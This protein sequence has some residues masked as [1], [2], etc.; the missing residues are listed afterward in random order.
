MAHGLFLG[1]DEIKS[2]P[3]F[4]I[5]T[6]QIINVATDGGANERNYDATTDLDGNG[7]VDAF[8]DVI[9]V[10]DN[11]KIEGLDEL[12]MEG[13]AITDTLRDWYKDWA[14]VP[15]PGI[16]APPFS[17]PGWI[18][19]VADASEFANTIGQKLE[20]IITEETI[21][22]VPSIEGALAAGFL[23]VGVISMVSSLASAVSNL[24]NYPSNNLAYKINN[25]L[26]G[27]FKKWLYEFIS[28]KQKFIV[29]QK[30]GSPFTLT[31]QE[32]F[33]FA[34]SLSVLT[35]VFSY[36]KAGNFNQIL[37]LIPIVFSISILIE[38]LRNFVVEAVAKSQGV[39]SEYHLWYFGLSAILFTALTFQAPFSWPAR[40]CHHSPRFTI[41]SLGLVSLVGI[42]VLL[43]SATIFY[44]LFIL[45]P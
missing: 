6:K 22:W 25:A 1:W 35:F 31:R 37:P 43:A 41:R 39:W 28:S 44:L 7:S 38:F 19:V 15:Q 17:K 16:S 8:D 21:V 14:L 4:P 13:I 34:L 42:T 3:N 23:T 26:P 5:A 32:I 33:S 12:D 30:V 11:A 18:R 2:S 10:V 24:G 36:A 9:S 27:I 29:M 20:V 45:H 40:M